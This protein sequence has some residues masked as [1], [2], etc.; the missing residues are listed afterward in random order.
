MEDTGI[1][2][3]I[4]ALRE[5]IAATEAAIA[6]LQSR[7]NQHLKAGEAG[8]A[9]DPASAEAVE[10]LGELVEARDSMTVRLTRLESCKRT[11]DA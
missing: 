2:Q 8:E 9:G 7:A 4:A 10:L 6:R 5:Q 3:E 11:P 1:S